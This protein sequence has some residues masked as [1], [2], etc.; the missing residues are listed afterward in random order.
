[1]KQTS[2]IPVLTA[3]GV[4]VLFC[5]AAG[6]RH[7][8][9]LQTGVFW[10]ILRDNA[11]L[12]IVAIGETFVILSGG[13][14]LSVG[15]MIGLTSVCVAAMVHGGM[16]PI[17]AILI[18]LA[19]GTAFGGA[20]GKIVAFF[21]IPPFLVTLAGLFLARGVGYLISTEATT[22][23]HPLYDKLSETQWVTPAIFAAVFLAGHYLLH[24]RP[25]GRT[26]FAI[27]GSEASTNLMGLEAGRT[28]TW[29][30]A[31]SGF[32]AALGGVVYT[33]GTA[34]GDPNAGVTLELDA[35]TAVV[36]GGT[37]LTGGYGSLVGTFIGVMLLGAI[38]SAINFEDNLSS[39]WTR[40]IIGVLLLIFLLV[41]KA[42]EKGILSRAAAK[43]AR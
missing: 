14:D 34:S 8:K 29:L 40:I 23:S 16:H 35:I 28:K 11:F 18:A 10:D 9:F 17:L 37:L 24:F 3:L 39:W 33:F 13:I 5:V 22:I 1:M 19:I 2:R 36:V 43:T 15:S 27:G 38:N 31:L 20:M 21:E 26:V 12:G 42:V 41:Q 6:L 7:P 30:Y 4:F 25:F 32:C